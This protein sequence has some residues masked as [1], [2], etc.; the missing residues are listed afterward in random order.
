MNRPDSLDLKRTFIK[1][2]MSC[3]RRFAIVG[4]H[5]DGNAMRPMEDWLRL[6]RFAAALNQ[7]VT[8]E[9]KDS[10]MFM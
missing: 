1:A 4:H 7:S 5:C 6:C 10:K 9:F 2:W 8:Q 3:L